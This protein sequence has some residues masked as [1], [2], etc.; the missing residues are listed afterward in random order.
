MCGT[1]SNFSLKIRTNATAAMIPIGR[2]IQKTHGQPIVVVI[3]P[4]TAGPDDRRPAPHGAEQALDLGALGRRVDVADDREGDRLKG[5]GAEPLDRSKDDQLDHRR[6]EAAGQRSDDEDDEPEHED[7]LSA[8][9]VGE[10]AEEGHRRRCGQEVAGED[11]RVLGEAAQLADDR[12]HR[13]AD[14]AR[15]ERREREGRQ[16]R[17]GDRE[18]FPRDRWIGVVASA[19]GPGHYP[20]GTRDRWARGCWYRSRRGGG[21]EGSSVRCGRNCRRAA[22]PVPGPGRPAARRPVLTVERN[23]VKI[24]A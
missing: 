17:G 6:G 19:T 7:R 22:K 3:T 20:R 16:D 10:L 15:I 1:R 18:L 24:G 23:T 2:L 5:P 21:H 4:P 9:H 11:P 8:V 12:R 13:R 14:H